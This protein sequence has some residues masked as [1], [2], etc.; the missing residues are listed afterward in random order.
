VKLSWRARRRWSLV[1]LLLAL[2]AYI[3]VAV[4]V[5]NALD[6]PPLVVELLV[7]VTLGIAWALPLRFVFR[8]IGREEERDP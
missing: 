2:P 4:S 8:G 5:M 6:R 7:Y 1:V 3:V